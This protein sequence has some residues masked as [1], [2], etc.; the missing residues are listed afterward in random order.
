MLASRIEAHPGLH[1][2]HIF[3]SVNRARDTVCLRKSRERLKIRRQIRASV[4]VALKVPNFYSP[5]REHHLSFAMLDPVT[6][7]SDV[8]SPICPLH[9]SEA[10]PLIISVLTLVDITTGPSKNAIAMLF[11]V[12][13]VSLVLITSSRSSSRV[14][15]P[16]TRPM[17]ETLI[18]FANKVR[19]VCGP[20]VL[21]S[22]M[23]LAVLEFPLICVSVCE[24]VHSGAVLQALLPLSL[25][26]IAILPQVHAIALGL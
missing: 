15:P 21:T 20:H 9:L 13:I 7:V 2:L 11:V 24:Y 12:L 1:Q 16:T 8:K 23:S 4:D 10:M 6:P 18:E 19:T 25:I 26:A 5:I 22:A 14:A 17:L 3:L